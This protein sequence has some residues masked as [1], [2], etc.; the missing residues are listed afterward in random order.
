M[1]KAEERGWMDRV[2][3][4]GESVRLTVG[5]D[6]GFCL[7]SFCNY[8]KMDTMIGARALRRTIYIM[9][10]DVIFYSFSVK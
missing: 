8:K 10:S 2:G 9:S 6:E 4:R 1:G 7:T 5:G 3:V